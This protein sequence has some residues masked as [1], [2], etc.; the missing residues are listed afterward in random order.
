M[1]SGAVF[2]LCQT[3]RYAL[4]RIW[5]PSQPKVFFIGLNPST[6][7]AVRNDPTARRCIGFAQRW[8]YGGVYM[9]NLFAYRAT[10]PRLLKTAAAPIGEKTD[11][12]LQ[13]LSQQSVLHIAAWGNHGC[14]LNRDQ[15]VRRLIP[16]LYCLAV[17]QQGQP[18]H[19]LYLKRELMPRPFP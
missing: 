1:E 9:A 5:D 4:W 6:A 3:Y 10:Q 17:T 11:R 14:F 19:P 7:D 18:S 2:S 8:G 16:D 12:W 13:Q 15:Q